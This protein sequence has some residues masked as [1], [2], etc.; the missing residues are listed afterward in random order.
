MDLTQL[1]LQ[2]LSYYTVKAINLYKNLEIKILLASSSITYVVDR[3][4]K[5]G[6]GKY[7]VVWTILRKNDNETVEKVGILCTEIVSF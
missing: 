2:C 3:L 6:F 4:E 5:K 7:L 1:N